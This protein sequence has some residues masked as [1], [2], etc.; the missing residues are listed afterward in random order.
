MHA[1]VPVEP[2]S[3]SHLSFAPGELCAL[4]VVCGGRVDGVFHINPADKIFG[5]RLVNLPHGS[6]GNSSDIEEVE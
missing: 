5:R 6:E 1:P 2:L 4:S 3:M